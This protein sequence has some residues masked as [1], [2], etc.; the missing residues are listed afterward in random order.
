MLNLV[1]FAKD[2][3]VEIRINYDDLLDGYEITM[4]RANY[5]TTY[6]VH[7]QE[8]ECISEENEDRYTEHILDRMLDELERYIAGHRAY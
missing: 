4:S 2:H 8:L 6:T 7:W 5:R 1:K 3:D